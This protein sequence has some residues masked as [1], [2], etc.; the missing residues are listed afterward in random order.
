MP[1]V[2][3]ILIHGSGGIGGQGASVDEWTRQLN[4]FGIAAFALD[5]FAGRGIVSTVADQSQLGRL[6]MVVDAYRALQT[7]ANHPRID[8]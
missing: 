6:N 8:A 7:L 4:Q 3:V 1:G 5:S 2:A